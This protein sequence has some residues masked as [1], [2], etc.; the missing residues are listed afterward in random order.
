MTVVPEPK[1]HPIVGR[2]LID[3]LEDRVGQLLDAAVGHQLEVGGS[4]H[5]PGGAVGEAPQLE[6]TLV[7]T[8]DVGQIGL[9]RVGAELGPR[10]S[11][12]QLALG[13]HAGKKEPCPHAAAKIMT[14]IGRDALCVLLG[15]IA[16][17]A[18]EELAAADEGIGVTPGKADSGRSPRVAVAAGLDARM[19]A[20]CIAAAQADKVDRPA[21]SG[22]AKGR[23]VGAAVDLDI[24]RR[25]RLDSLHVEATIGQI[26]G[27]AILQE[28]QAAAMEGALQT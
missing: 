14:E 21:Q 24:A 16:V 3:D 28:Q 15:V 7:V 26:K 17:A 4:A 25:Q 8:G 18:L 6:V 10:Q 27:H 1:L 13:V 9:P 5:L 12:G 23:G 20:R 19:H 11:P 2:V 22:G